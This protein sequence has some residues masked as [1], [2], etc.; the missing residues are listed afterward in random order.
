MSSMSQFRRQSG[1]KCDC[2]LLKKER[3]GERE[4]RERKKEKE[5]EEKGREEEEEVTL[6]LRPTDKRAV[7]RS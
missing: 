3:A 6:A 5:G 4:R 7:R 2:C 1:V